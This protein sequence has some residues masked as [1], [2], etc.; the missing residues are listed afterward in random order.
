MPSSAS[1]T[2]ASCVGLLLSQYF[3]G[4]KRIREPLA[5]PRISEPRKVEADAHATETNSET[6]SPESKIFDFRA[7][8]SEASTKS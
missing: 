7:A 6:E 5:P 2:L 4:A 8:I 1:S 3:W